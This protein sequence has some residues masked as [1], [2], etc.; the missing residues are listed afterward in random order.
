MDKNPLKVNKEHTRAAMKRFW[1]FTKGYRLL[2]LLCPFLIF[3]DVLIEL[4][5]P[6]AMSDVVNIFYASDD[7]TFNLA[8][9]QNELVFSLLKM[10]G[11]CALALLIGYNFKHGLWRKPSPC[12]FQ[13][14][15][16]PLL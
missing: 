9:V 13:Q 12:T 15:T 1:G 2:T 8:A 16:G 4:E 6:D 7:T 3:A 5:I 10:L 14:N 11:L